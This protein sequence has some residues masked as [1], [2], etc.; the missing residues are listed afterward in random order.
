V[1]GHRGVQ[2]TLNLL[3]SHGKIWQTMVKDVEDF[4]QACPTCQKV[5]FGEASGAAALR[6]TAVEEP[7]STFVIGTIGPLPADSAGNQYIVVVMDGFSRFVELR[8]TKTAR[9]QEAAIA[10]LEVFGRYGAPKFVRS[11][12]GPQFTANLIKEFLRLVGSSPQY[13]IAYRHESNGIVERTNREVGRHLRSIVMDK[14]V[15][16]QWSECLPFVQRIL[17]STVNRSIGT[18]PARILFGDAIHLDREIIRTPE[19][20][21]HESLQTT[22]EDYVQNLT[23]LQCAIVEASQEHMRAEVEHRLSKSPENPRSLNAG[24]YVL[25]SYPERA[26]NKLVPRWRGPMLVVSVQG[27]MCCVQ[28][29]RTLK[30]CDFHISRLKEYNMDQTP[31]PLQ[32]AQVDDD[33]W[34]VSEIVDHRGR[35]KKNF[36]FRVRWKGFGEKDD[37][38]LPLKDCRDLEALDSYLQQHPG[39]KI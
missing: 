38:W 28:D 29:L 18:T 10:M 24:D 31:D 30:H 4:V 32:V 21:S 27:S 11:D 12:N 1:V 22:V 39:L 20:E 36:E 13:T 35:N 17:N 14:R 25:V 7:F 3:R 15:K 34:E 23:R 5:R 6:T 33:E 16:D 26:P 2:A 19:V 8:A 37:T 9:A